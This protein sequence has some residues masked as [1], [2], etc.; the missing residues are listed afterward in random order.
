M[1]PRFSPIERFGKTSLKNNLAADIDRE[2]KSSST[3]GLRGNLD[4]QERPRS[5]FADRYAKPSPPFKR[6]RNPVGK[7]I[8]RQDAKAAASTMPR[9]FKDSTQ[10]FRD[11]GIDTADKHQVDRDTPTR[12]QSFRIPDMTGI[13]SLFDTTP[14]PPNQK[15]VSPKYV[16]ITSV[17]LPDEEKGISS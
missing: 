9:S 12:N 15:R 1:K 11:L 16:P 13:H 3:P 17:P 4:L 8:E 6:P 14:K 7:T 5:A 10:L 2:L